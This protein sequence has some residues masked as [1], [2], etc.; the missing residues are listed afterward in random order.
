MPLSLS[1]HGV[2]CPHVR[3]NPNDPL[4]VLPH[5]NKRIRSNLRKS[6]IG[7]EHTPE[8]LQELLGRQLTV[9]LKI[10]QRDAREFVIPL[11][12][13][14]VLLVTEDFGDDFDVDLIGNVGSREAF[15]KLQN[16][17]LVI[18]GSTRS[19]SN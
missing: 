3:R 10:Y 1:S 2:P 13:F 4:Y 14:L 8:V 5:H 11:A 17:R 7:D 9:M 16:F 19:H 18:L 6:G 15:H 12:Q